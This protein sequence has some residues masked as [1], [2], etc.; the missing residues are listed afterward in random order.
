MLFLAISEPL[1]TRSFAVVQDRQQFWSWVQPL[2]D[3]GCIRSV[4]A[5]VGRGAVVL[6]DVADNAELHRHLNAWCD[7]IP[8]RFEIHALIDP[9][10]A[11]SFLSER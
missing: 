11:R 7:M 1:P 10:A 2:K 8:A 4:H 6:F 9:D 5:K 3:A